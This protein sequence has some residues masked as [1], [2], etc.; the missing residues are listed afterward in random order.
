MTKR[1]D[2]LVMEKTEFEL[3]DN[4]P[5]QRIDWRYPQ[6]Y[7]ALGY[8]LQTLIEDGCLNAKG[9]KLVAQ[10]QESLSKQIA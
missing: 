8:Y 1:F 10:W 3:R 4:T 5:Q 9:K 2:D 6:A 7:G